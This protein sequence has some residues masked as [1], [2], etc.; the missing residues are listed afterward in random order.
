MKGIYWGVVA[1]LML[2]SVGVNGCRA[3]KDDAPGK[4]PA[5]TPSAPAV[6]SPAAAPTTP[7]PPP[8]LATLDTTAPFRLD[9]LRESLGR[10]ILKEI[11]PKLLIFNKNKLQA[12]NITFTSESGKFDFNQ[13]FGEAAKGRLIV[14]ASG[15]YQK[16]ATSSGPQLL[17]LNPAVVDAEFKAYPF[18]SLCGRTLQVSGKVRCTLSMVYGY[19]TDT[20]DVGGQCMSHTNGTMDNLQ[21]VLGSDVH[22]VRYSVQVKGHGAAT[23]F[24]SYQWL[25]TAA[26]DGLE[27]SL[28]QL[29]GSSD[30]CAK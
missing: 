15:A 1:A 22:K 30:Q 23:D 4:A 13:N 21:V 7:P 10:S 16:V 29:P 26:V 9:V 12:E 14:Q 27:M 24:A 20:I 28:T 11:N 17:Y 8:P 2:S 6:S 18:T 19:A 25:G 3:L 5:S